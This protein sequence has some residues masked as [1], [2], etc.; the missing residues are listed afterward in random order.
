MSLIV[1][2]ATTAS[3]QVYKTSNNNRLVISGESSLGK[4][5]ILINGENVIQNVSVYDK[6]NLKGSYK[7]HKIVAIC[8]MH[9]KAF[10]S[11]QE[12]DVYI[13][14]EYAANLYFR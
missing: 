8:K 10:G 4:I 13:D 5:N 3:K 14:E 7:G 11:N 1:G 2:C 6:E 9:S 12:C